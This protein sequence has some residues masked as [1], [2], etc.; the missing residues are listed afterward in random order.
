[1]F[2]GD[3]PCRLHLAHQ[4]RHAGVVIKW[5]RFL[6]PFELRIGS[7]LSKPKRI[8][9]IPAEIDICHQCHIGT[10]SIACSEDLRH[11]L[12]ESFFSFRDSVTEGQLAGGETV[13]CVVT[14]IGTGGISGDFKARRI[15]EKTIDRRVKN[16]S[17]EIDEC[18]FY[19]AERV[20]H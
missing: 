15:G 13:L 2:T 18:E 12:R 7:R 8:I 10:D 5:N 17:T 11:V 9:Y 1:M 4:L 14:D 20:N 19:A 3:N 6:N 16:L